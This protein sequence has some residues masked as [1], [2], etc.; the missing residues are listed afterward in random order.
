MNEIGKEKEKVSEW[1][2]ETEKRS[3]REWNKEEKGAWNLIE[4]EENC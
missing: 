3:G 4:R 2:G 1:D